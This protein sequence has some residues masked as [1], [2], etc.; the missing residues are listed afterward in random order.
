MKQPLS[1]SLSLSQNILDSHYTREFENVF[2]NLK[3]G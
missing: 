1:L 2:E 3:R